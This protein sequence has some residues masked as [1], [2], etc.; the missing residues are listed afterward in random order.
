[1]TDALQQQR[2]YIVTANAI[3]FAGD[4]PH[5]REIDEKDIETSTIPFG[6]LPTSASA[7]A[8]PRAPHTRSFRF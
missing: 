2:D 7:N 1:M 4:R 8:V 5:V 3:H 6:E